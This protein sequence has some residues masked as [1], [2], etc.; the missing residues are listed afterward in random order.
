MPVGTGKTT[1]VGSFAGANTCHEERHIR[2]LGIR[3][4]ER[5]QSQTRHQRGASTNDRHVH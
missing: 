2:L 1:K 3:R 5:K 4:R